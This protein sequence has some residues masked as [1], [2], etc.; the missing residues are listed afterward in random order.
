MKG[1][2]NRIM[3]A[4]LAAI[5][6]VGAVGA[7]EMASSVTVSAAATTKLSAPSNIKK[8]VTSNSVKLSWDKVKGADYYEVQL[9]NKSTGKYKT[10]KKV[11]STGCK[12]TGLKSG[13]EYKVKLW[14]VDKV[15]GKNTRQKSKTITFKTTQ[16]KYLTLN[17]TTLKIEEG[18]SATLTATENIGK[19]VEWSIGNSSF[20]TISANGNKVTINAIKTGSTVVTAKCGSKTAKCT[21]TVT[22]KP[23]SAADQKWNDCLE[24]YRNGKTYEVPD[25]NSITVKTSSDGLD[26]SL[27]KSL[28]LYGCTSTN[29]IDYLDSKVYTT[30]DNSSE[31]QRIL[32]AGS[33]TVPSAFYIMSGGSNKLVG[34]C[35][36]SGYVETDKTSIVKNSTD[37]MWRTF[38]NEYSYD[39][40]F[41]S[42]INENIDGDTNMLM[43]LALYYINS[44]TG[45]TAADLGF[46]NF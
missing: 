37:Y 44:D 26:I 18:T 1:I 36:F 12:L 45:I 20:A 16:A 4:V 7:A 28:T 2:K 9:Y 5:I 3:S 40:R 15:N 14:T 21:V 42:K 41:R 29:S 43:A 8:V 31:T 32:L 11:T 34:D 10:V 35:T 17:K 19:K 25:G 33:G 38:S 46:T 24:F 39:S 23:L 6:S 22:G 13:T 30:V 27:N